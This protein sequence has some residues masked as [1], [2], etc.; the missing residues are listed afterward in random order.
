MKR[1]LIFILCFALM[2][3]AVACDDKSASESQS[4]SRAVDL[5][6][7][8]NYPE[9][10]RNL[11]DEMKRKQS[12][13]AATP[14]KS[15]ADAPNRTDQES[16]PPETPT[17]A[18][19][20]EL[21]P[22]PQESI[23]GQIHLRFNNT[24]GDLMWGF[25][26]VDYGNGRVRNWTAQSNTPS[27]KLLPGTYAIK[28]TTGAEKAVLED[29]VVTAG[30]ELNFNDIVLDEEDVETDEKD[31]EFVEFSAQDMYARLPLQF[32]QRYDTLGYYTTLYYDEAAEEDTSKNQIL[33]QMDCLDLT[34][35]RPDAITYEYIEDTL[36]YTL[37]HHDV[38]I[39]NRERNAYGNAYMME[40]TFELEDGPYTGKSYAVFDGDYLYH[41]IV[42]SR[43]EWTAE[44]QSV[45]DDILEHTWIG[46]SPLKDF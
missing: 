6:E 26:R 19:D 27:F 15:S 35:D 8:R 3:A 25:V 36:G 18:D 21:F 4:G 20:P 31:P 5:P 24:A 30:S 28:I 42:S 33:Y 40:L 1:A 44:A 22:Y 17:V 10:A 11:I 34:E 32:N 37:D 41:F 12:G 38:T 39:S 23:R 7:D 46:V 43:H 16:P 2:F 14:D 29:V 9:A 45:L 13:S